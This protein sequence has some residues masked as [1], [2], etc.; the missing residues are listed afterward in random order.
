MTRQGPVI[1]LGIGVGSGPGPRLRREGPAPDPGRLTRRMLR[2]LAVL[3][4]GRQ[5][6]G[7]LVLP[8]IISIITGPCSLHLGLRRIVSPGP[9]LIIIM[10]VMS[11]DKEKSGKKGQTVQAR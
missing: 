7:L 11:V 10:K 6:S 5:R 2:G 4:G 9:Y 1:H 8:L 3:R